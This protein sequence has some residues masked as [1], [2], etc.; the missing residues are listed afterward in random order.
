[1]TSS[2]VI[3]VRDSKVDTPR[4]A[5]ARW[6]RRRRIVRMLMRRSK[7][8][9]QSTKEFVAWVGRAAVHHKG[10]Y[11]TIIDHRGPVTVV[12]IT[13]R[14]VFTV[15]RLFRD[16]VHAFKDVVQLTVHPVPCV[17]QTSV[18]CQEIVNRFMQPETELFVNDVNV[19]K[20]Q[21]AVRRHGSFTCVSCGRLFKTLEV[22]LQHVGQAKTNASLF[23]VVGFV[24]ADNKP[25]QD[26]LRCRS[27][28]ASVHTYLKRILN[29]EVHPVLLAP[30]STH[31]RNPDLSIVRILHL[32][33]QMTAM[34]TVPDKWL[35]ALTSGKCGCHTRSKWVAADGSVM[36]LVKRVRGCTAHVHTPL[37][38]FVATL[39]SKLADLQVRRKRL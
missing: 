8:H 22:Y 26:L 33:R 20:L 3:V 16:Q 38:G 18:S 5:L 34:A 10:R 39:I 24:D 17:I 23:K 29:R 21:V 36:R 6:A 37:S 31:R 27:S 19:M 1:M 11:T 14:K 13:R 2:P 35:W 30:N 7:L 32:D 9:I 12:A 28:P 25:L 4:R 15:T